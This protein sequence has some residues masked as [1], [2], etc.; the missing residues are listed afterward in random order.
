[1]KPNNMYNDVMM[2]NPG[3]MK[4]IKDPIQ[5]SML[6]GRPPKS[7]LHEESKLER[8]DVEMYEQNIDKCI[9]CNRPFTPREEQQQLKVMFLS[10]ECYH[11]IHKQCLAETAVQQIKK[12]KTIVC[13]KGDCKKQI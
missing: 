4:M 2:D 9:L 11:M 1:M 10:T 7:Q 12:S 3:Q 8:F 13:P 5:P 6:M